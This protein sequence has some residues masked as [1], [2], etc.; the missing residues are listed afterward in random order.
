[1]TPPILCIAHRGASAEAPENTLPAFARAIE[2]GVDGIELDVQ[3][4]R[5]GVPVVFHDTALRRLT[6]VS[7][8]LANCSKAD[9]RRLNVKGEPIPTLAEVLDFVRGRV[10][11]QVEIK[12]AVE[13]GPVVRVIRRARAR[14]NTILASS[15]FEVLRAAGVLAPETTRMLIDP[16]RG[17]RAANLKSA[18]RLLGAMARVGASGVSIDHRRVQSAAFVGFLQARGAQVWCWTVN[19]E[20]RQRQLQ[21]WGVDAILSDDPARLIRTLCRE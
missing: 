18:G 21:A 4:T 10:V 8:R 5:D 7:G 15:D 19:A 3:L 6:G 20:S 11:L 2:L 9:L 17:V 16:A 13:V 14:R 1:V 12:P